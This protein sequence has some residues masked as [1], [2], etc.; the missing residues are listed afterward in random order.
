MTRH[1]FDAS[2][3]GL[4]RSGALAGL[5]LFS[6]SRLGAA[7]AAAARW[8]P[9]LQLYTLGD[10]PARDLDGT[11]QQLAAIGYRAVE[12]AGHYGR[13]AVDLRRSLDR[14][15]LACTSAHLGARPHAGNWSLQDDPEQLVADL[16]TLGAAYAV[17]PAPLPPVAEP[18]RSE[19]W[20]RT[21]RFLNDKGALLARSGLRIAYHNHATE[22]ERAGDAPSGFEVLLAETDP[23]C[24]DFQ[25]DVGWAA[26]AGQ[27]IDRL[28]ALAGDRIRLLHLKDTGSGPPE[29]RQLVSTNV[30]TGIV[31]WRRL[32]RLV[33]THDIRHA[34]VEQEPPFPGPPMDSVRAAY[35]F[36][37]VA[38]AEDR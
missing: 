24:V 11:L 23:Q 13:S 14:A 31:D 37:S 38:F 25:L 27:D 2:R 36:L 5:A 9:G 32:V 19:D 29:A 20:K 28:F 33:R 34:Y 4:L 21:A 16:R 12:L 22:F 35:E 18:F 30:G 10:A 8:T 7:N 15:G 26:A 6:V 17:L 3:R 1:R